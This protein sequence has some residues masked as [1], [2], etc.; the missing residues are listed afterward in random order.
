MSNEAVRS[1]VADV[2]G[3]LTVGKKAVVVEVAP[4]KVAE[5]C[6]RIH[7]IPGLY[8]LSTITGMDL[9]DNIAILYHFWQGTSFV[10][11]RTQ[12]PKSAPR[13]ES[14]SN[15]VPA[16]VLYEAEIKDLLGVVF[17]GNP[18]MKTR[19]LLPDEYPASAP[20]PLTKEADPAQVRRM[21]GLE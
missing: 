8:H 7:S 3:R 13:L 14:I 18:F 15:A 1:A 19:L 2:G 10:V 11:V 6:S 20:P 21:M 5:A 17:E 16:A 12:V 9:G 4:E